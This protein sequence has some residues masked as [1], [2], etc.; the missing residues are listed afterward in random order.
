MVVSAMLEAGHK[1]HN[2]LVPYGDVESCE[3]VQESV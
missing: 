2:G 3:G 1:L